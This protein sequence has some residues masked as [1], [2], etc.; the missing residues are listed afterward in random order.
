LCAD[1]NG[2]GAPA[3]AEATNTS[4]EMTTRIFMATETLVN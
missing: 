2:S 1:E 3:K 4:K